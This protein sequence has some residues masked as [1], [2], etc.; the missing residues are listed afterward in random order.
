MLLTIAEKMKIVKKDSYYIK[1]Y[2][3]WI[4]MIVVIGAFALK[5]KAH[6]GFVIIPSVNGKV[7]VGCDAIT[8]ITEI[9][10]QNMNSVYKSKVIVCD[11][12]YG[13]KCSVFHSPLEVEELQKLIYA[14]C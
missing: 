2:L 14:D 9:R 12:I 1:L 10:N 5:A 8:R 3:A 7:L 11:Q 6:L 4:V 13:G